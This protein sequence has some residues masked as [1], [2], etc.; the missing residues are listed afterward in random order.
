MINRGRATDQSQ[1]SPSAPQ[2]RLTQ[3]GPGHPEGQ[4]SVPEPRESPTAAAAAAPRGSGPHH[5]PTHLP[6][7]RGC[8]QRP[9]PRGCGKS[10]PRTYRRVGQEPA[11]LGLEPAHGPGR[12]GIEAEVAV[13]LR[14]AP[15]QQRQRLLHG[16]C[17]AGGDC[18]TSPVRFL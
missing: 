1:N 11:Q 17:E 7:R 3:P 9:A 8:A 2:A 13:P 10:G 15:D 16:G 18:K 4:V 6:T 5:L 14:G 12:L